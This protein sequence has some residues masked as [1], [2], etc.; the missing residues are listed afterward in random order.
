MKKDVKAFEIERSKWSRGKGNDVYNYLLD[1]EGK[2]CCLGF[3]ALACGFSTNEIQDIESPE[4]VS[5][6]NWDTFLVSKGFRTDKQTEDAA[7]LM[8]T[9][10]SSKISDEERE[11]IIT[12]IFKK[13][14]IDVTFKD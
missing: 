7:T 13:H 9:N 12:D 14:N 2:M 8:A 3:Y 11:S 10:D 4:Q 1:A 5:R 6:C